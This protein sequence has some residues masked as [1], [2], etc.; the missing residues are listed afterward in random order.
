MDFSITQD[1]EDF[2]EFVRDWVDREA[3]KSAALAWEKEE[4]TFPEDLFQKMASA[5][6]HGVGI[7][8]EYGGQGGDIV[9]QML[10]ARGLSRSLAGLTWVWGITSFAGGKSVG[11]YGSE[12]QKKHYLP[13]ICSGEDK[14]AIGF[15]EP[16]GGTDLL[17]AMRTRARKVEGGWVVNGQKTWSSMAHVADNILLLARTEETE[18]RTQGLTLFIL[19]AK[20]EGVT[21]REIPKLGMRALGSCDVFLDEVFI[22]DE[23]VLGEPGRAWYMLLPTLNNERVMLASF[24]VGI[25]DGVLEDALR[26]MD[27]REAFGGKIGRFQALQHHVA[28]IAMWREQSELVVFKAAWMQATG[29]D[30]GAMSNMAKVIA[31]ELAGQGADLGLQILGGMGYSAETNMQRYWRDVRLFRIGPITNEMARN[32]IAEGLGLPRSF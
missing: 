18:K 32:G 25:L 28:N 23:N 10:L 8:E 16:G 29:R 5:G 27:E 1:Q 19:P 6:F 26:Y 3:P 14:W 13:R 15:T 11:L 9:T 22:P 4:H 20:S 2:V 31:S 17:G 7:P 30:A 21:I 12:E 24:C